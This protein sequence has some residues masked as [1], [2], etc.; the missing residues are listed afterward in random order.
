MTVDPRTHRDQDGASVLAF[1]LSGIGGGLLSGIV[2]R[3]TFGH[4]RPAYAFHP[5]LGATPVL[6]VVAA[7]IGGVL[8]EWSVAAVILSR[9]PGMFRCPR[10]ASANYPT[11]GSCAACGLS[12]R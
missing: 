3:L 5:Y 1:V 10:C 2:A 8:G 4:L 6:I 9:T 11:S 12:F 7:T